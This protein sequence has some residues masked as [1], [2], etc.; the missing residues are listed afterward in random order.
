MTMSRMVLGMSH[1]PRSG[2]CLI[3][4]T[5]CA[6]QGRRHLGICFHCFHLRSVLPLYRLWYL[7]CSSL[8]TPPTRLQ[9]LAQ[10]APQVDQCV[11][12]LSSSVSGPDLIAL[13]AV[14]TPWASHAFNPMDGYLQ[15]LPYHIYAFMFPMHKLTFLILFGVINL[16]TIAIHDSDMIHDHPLEKFINGPAHHTLHHMYFTVNYGQCALRNLAPFTP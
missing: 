9:A 8:R 15:S 4:T 10:A 12:F 5:M 3:L 6:T 1:H 13:T 14:P 7:L 2:E 16:W 11:E